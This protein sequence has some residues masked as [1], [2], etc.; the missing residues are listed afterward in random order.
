[1]WLPLPGC[2]GSGRGGFLPS[3]QGAATMPDRAEKDAWRQM[4]ADHEHE[5]HERREAARRD[6]ATRMWV[7]NTV[8]QGGRRL[9]LVGGTDLDQPP[10]PPWHPPETA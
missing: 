5:R 1:M 2:C 10:P 6:L 8:A 4:A 9:G 7:M 3:D